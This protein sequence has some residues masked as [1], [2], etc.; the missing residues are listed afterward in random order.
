MPL[1]FRSKSLGVIFFWL[2]MLPCVSAADDTPLFKAPFPTLVD[3]PLIKTGDLEPVVARQ[4]KGFQNA[5]QQF[6]FVGEE[7]TAELGTAYGLLGQV[8]HAYKWMASARRCYL[9][10]AALDPHAFRWQYL[11]ALAELDQGNS[12][13]AEAAF[14]RAA[15]LNPNYVATYIRL[16]EV[17]LQFNDH[18]GAEKEF[19]KAFALAPETPA[20]QVGMGHVYQLRKEYGKALEAFAKALKQVPVASKVNY[21]I[22]MTYRAMGKTDEARTFMAKAGKVGIRP[23]DPLLDDVE[24][25][26]RGERVLMQ[27]GHAAFSASQYQSAAALYQRVLKTNPENVAAMI[28]LGTCLG[29]LGDINAAVENYR[30]ALVLEPKNVTANVNLGKLFADAQ[31]WDMARQHIKTALDIQPEDLEV[32]FQ[33]ANVL[34]ELGEFEQALAIYRSLEEKEPGNPAIANNTTRLLVKANRYGDALTALEGYRGRFPDEPQLAYLHAQ[35]LVG[36]PSLSERDG[37]RALDIAGQMLQK[38]NQ[39]RFVETIA[40]AYAEL[41]D[42]EKAAEWQA[43][44]VATIRESDSVQGLDQ[45]QRQL[46]YYQKGGNC[47]IQGQ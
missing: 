19:Q 20:A 47:A 8:Y 35:I 46:T 16:G 42:C 11:L 13:E 3:V 29:V 44:V 21:N 23:V 2:A 38:T 31:Q 18:Q 14:R 22:A 15:T 17:R 7:N 30:A 37:K 10:A 9:N 12:E 1:N 26:Q 43:K 39:L 40:M 5:L 45:A 6:R 41:G 34:T 33:F 27:Q 4:V 28:N 25:L 36:H 24:R 32:Q